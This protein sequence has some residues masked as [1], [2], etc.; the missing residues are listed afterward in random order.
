MKSEDELAQHIP[1]ILIVDDVPANLTILGAILKNAGYKV[2]PVPNGMLALQVASKEKPD[3]ILLDI[4]MPDMDGF[5][6]CCRLK[7]NPKLSDVPVIFISALNDTKDIV[8]ALSSG[9]VD[10]ITKP[11]KAEEV[12]A[13]VNTHLKLYLQ[14][15]ELQAQSK[16]LK[17]LNAT[18]D[19]F[20]SIIAHDLRGPLG[21]FMGLSEMMADERQAFEPD[22]MKEM[23]VDL[24]HSARNIYNLLENLLEWSQ[25]QRGGTAFNPQM[26]SLKEAVSECLKL[27][28][29]SANKKDIHIEAD[30]SKE[31]SVYADIN[32]LHT[33]IR[34][35]LS[36]AV[37]FTQRGGVVSIFSGIA[38]NKSAVIGVKDTGIGMNSEMVSNLFRINVNSSRPG[39]EGENSTGLGLLLCKEFVEKHGGELW[40]E[41]EPN[42]GSVF[43][44]TIPFNIDTIQFISGD[45]A[46]SSGE[47]LDQIESEDTGLKI[48]IAEDNEN[49]EKL[50]RILARNF[51]NEVLEAATGGEAVDVCRANPDVDLVFMDI[52]MPVM[53]GLEATR[54]IRQFNKKVVI[55][56]QT[57]FGLPGYREMAIEAGCNDYISKPIQ[58]DELM[59]LVQK[60]FGFRNI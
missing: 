19:K 57:A 42:K 3:L 30:I 4:M 51:S 52:K 24:S 8:K 41:S 53:D 27:V 12:K 54:Q 22:E 7:E 13:R 59:S 20:F 21:G 56:A 33:V 32:M 34:N 28:V 47:N 55:I 16:E 60:Y 38:E 40:V 29:E 14:S 1:D 25:M 58:K 5:E 45:P 23:I 15:K 11:F 18:K 48:L 43:Y 6:V 46:I 9:G 36:N 37:K 10:F 49:S 50:I 39:T 2:R 35:L 26:V 31:H 44:F 17:E